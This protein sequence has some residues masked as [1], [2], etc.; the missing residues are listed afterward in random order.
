[1]KTKAVQKNRVVR[2]DM[3]VVVDELDLVGGSGYPN[4]GVASDPYAISA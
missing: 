1:M 3:S 2:V 4:T